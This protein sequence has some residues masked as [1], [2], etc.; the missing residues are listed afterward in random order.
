VHYDKELCSEKK[1]ENVI[2][3]AGLR[4][5][6]GCSASGNLLLTHDFI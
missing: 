1:T 5:I 3:K 4:K 2:N 6:R